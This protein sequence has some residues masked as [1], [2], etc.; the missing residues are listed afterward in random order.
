ME[1][2]I[3]LEDCGRDDGT[4]LF[5]GDNVFLEHEITHATFCVPKEQVKAYFNLEENYSQP[6]LPSLD[7]FQAVNS[8]EH[9]VPVKQGV[10]VAEGGVDSPDTQDSFK[11]TEG[12]TM[13][14][15]TLYEENM[16]QVGPLKAFRNKKV[17]WEHIRLLCCKKF[18][19]FFSTDQI[20]GI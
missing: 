16:S 8:G 17:M 18:D 2:E 20:M 5:V 19:R 4:I 9:Q 1:M 15:L 12:Q 10:P 7:A 13:Y 3:S 14:L 11:W 6:Y